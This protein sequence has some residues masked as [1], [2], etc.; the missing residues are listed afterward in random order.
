VA[1]GQEHGVRL[2]SSDTAVRHFGRFLEMVDVNN[3]SP[4]GVAR[5]R[6]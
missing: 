2:I 5:V 1:A 4:L 6:E 3:L